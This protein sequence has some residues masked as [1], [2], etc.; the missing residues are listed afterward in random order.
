MLTRASFRNL[1]GLKAV[2]LDLSRLTVLV[3]KNGTGKTSILQGIHYAS[4]V[5]A[6]KAGARSAQ[7]RILT[8][9]SQARSPRRL[10]TLPG[11]GPLRIA[12]TNDE[13]RTLS[14]EAELSSGEDEPATSRLAIGISGES[15]PSIG[16]T[17]GD[18]EAVAKLLGLPAVRAFGSAVFLHLDASVM[19]RPSESAFEEP[20]LEYNGEGLAS[21]LSYFAGAEPEALESITKDLATVVPNVR[22]VRTFPA[23]VSRRRTERMIIDDQVIL[24]SFEEKVMG[25]R[26]SLEMGAG[27]VIP[28]DMLS[29]GTVLA[30]GLLVAFRQPRCPRLILMDDID[31][32]LHAPAQGELIRCIRSI[33]QSRPDVQIVCTSHSPYLL[34]HVGPEEVRVLAQDEEGYV[35]CAPLTAHPDSARF[36]N[37]LRTGELWA[38]LGEDWVSGGHGHPGMKKALAG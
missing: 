29:E 26:F 35:R 30:L 34:D 8:L 7:E 1:K 18:S 32:A 22:S 31:A 16:L 2:E 28:A 23:E 10:V 3:G 38:S 27:R 33:L 21:V 15:P 9:F 19:V 14:L 13:G 20:R 12:L 5:G 17:D 25:H 24:R 4:Q 11:R 37:M 6:G 36:R